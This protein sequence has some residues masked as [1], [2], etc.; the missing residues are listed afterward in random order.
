MDVEFMLSARLNIH[1][2]ITAITLFVQKLN[3]MLKMNI[4]CCVMLSK[5]I[6]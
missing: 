6:P 4:T 2:F 1:A 5:H 3:L